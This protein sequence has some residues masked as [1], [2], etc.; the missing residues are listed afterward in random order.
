MPKAI[1]CIGYPSQVD[2]VEA[3]MLDGL[4]RHA[5]TARVGLPLVKVDRLMWRVRERGTVERPAPRRSEWTAEKLEKARRL[6]DLTMAEIA[7]A[8]DVTVPDLL[9]AIAPAHVIA[10]PSREDDD[11][12]L[13]A[14]DASGGLDDN[15]DDDA[16]EPVALPPADPPR[17]AAVADE[18][19]QPAQEASSTAAR[20]DVPGSV[21]VIETRP[22]PTENGG[23]YPDNGEAKALTPSSEVPGASAGTQAPP[24][25]TPPLYRL[26]SDSGD[27]LEKSGVGLTRV[28][29]RA[30]VGTAA[31]I[32]QIYRR[33]PEYRNLDA[34]RAY[35]Q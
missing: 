14:L 35:V 18:A 28:L 8:L 29:R 16:L 26:K 13:T 11:A 2:A 30:W 21:P 5:I 6:F 12:E 20:M 22:V 4:D 10:E 34:E 3:L 24:V 17:L 25:E 32:E 9:R 15:Q 27:Y 7:K 33:R 1:P 19:D 31:Q 23:G